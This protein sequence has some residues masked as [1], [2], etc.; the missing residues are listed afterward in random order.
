VK[1]LIGKFEIKVKEDHES[2]QTLMNK[3]AQEDAF[4]KYMNKKFF[5]LNT[6]DKE[7]RERRLRINDL[8]RE[9]KFSDEKDRFLFL[10]EK[11]LQTNLE[12]RTRLNIAFNRTIK[13]V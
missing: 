2:T 1:D 12:L 11:T 3:A 4:R 5:K 10:I 7:K 13:Q 8:K 6:V 9:I